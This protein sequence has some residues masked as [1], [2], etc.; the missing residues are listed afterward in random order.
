VR[1]QQSVGLALHALPVG[2]DARGQHAAQALGDRPQRAQVLLAHA[3]GPPRLVVQGLA[4]AVDLA[5]VG[6][7]QPER[8][9][10]VS[11]VVHERTL[12]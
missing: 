6:V 4:Q 8:D 2:G 10:Q 12:P 11:S 7:G 3:F 9:V 1:G 5:Q